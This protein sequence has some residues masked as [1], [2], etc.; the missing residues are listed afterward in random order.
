MSAVSMIGGVPQFV[1]AD[2]S[3]GSFSF[4]TLMRTDGTHQRTIGL[5][6]CGGNL[7]M[8]VAGTSFVYAMCYNAVYGIDPINDVVSWI[9]PVS[10]VNS[11]TFAMVWRPA[12]LTGA[13][14]GDLL[15][16][17]ATG[18][19]ATLLGLFVPDFTGGPVVPTAHINYT[20]FGAVG[21][22]PVI[23]A[24]GAIYLF[25]GGGTPKLTKVSLI[26]GSTLATV[27]L[28]VSPVTMNLAGDGTLVVTSSIAGGLYALSGITITNGSPGT[29]TLKWQVGSSTFSVAP[30]FP[31]F[32]T[33]PAI[34]PDG[35]VVAGGIIDMLTANS[36]G[37]SQELSA[38]AAPGPSFLYG[39]PQWGVAGDP[40]NRGSAPGFD[41]TTT[42][43]CGAN[44]LCVLNHCIGT[45]RTAST[46]AAGQGCILANCGPCPIDSACRAGEVCNAGVCLSCNRATNPSCC[47][48]NAECGTGACVQ[49][50][51]RA[52]PSASASGVWLK[53]L[54]AQTSNTF[55]Q[56]QG[57]DGTLYVLDQV[58]LPSV[59]AFASDG[60]VLWTSPA[61]PTGIVLGPQL[62][63]VRVGA[64]DVLFAISTSSNT[65][66]TAVV[67]AAGFG[68]WK[69][70]VMTGLNASISAMAQGVSSALTPN[71]P[72]VYMSGSGKLWAVDPVAA[73]GGTFNPLWQQPNT[74]CTEPAT[75]G[76]NWV[77]VGSDATVYH[78]CSDGSVQAWHP[79]G[80]VLQ[81]LGLSRP[82][83]LLYTSTPTVLYP[84][85]P[86]P[87]PALA[88][89]PGNPDVLYLSQ[90]T[91]ALVSSVLRV[92][93]AGV[94]SRTE[95]LA[96]ANVGFVVDGAGNALA[97][98]TNTTQ[99]WAAIT[100]AGALAGTQSG[101]YSFSGA[102][103]MM[104]TDG[105]AWFVDQKATPYAVVGLQVNSLA[106]PTQAVRFVAQGGL[107]WDLTTALGF[108]PNAQST[109]GS[110]ML[111]GDNNLGGLGYAN[112]MLSG[113]PLSSGS[114]A[115]TTWGTA[116][117]DSQHRASLK[118]Q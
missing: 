66:F 69:S 3:G 23:D 11:Q 114:A 115:L 108:L 92:S 101:V 45:C 35:G 46:C 24:A 65:F 49:G 54:T 39:T 50:L 59:H 98:S 16:T 68:G 116:G 15:V 95:V 52:M 30:A 106:T 94:A 109:T 4:V 29:A 77:M 62:M 105:L 25:L 34:A 32:S 85:A 20:N 55:P 10:L 44:Q 8:L 82:G 118:V 5:S 40:G 79:D 12:G 41:C 47:A 89:I 73:A 81:P 111:F 97:F 103:V 88:A 31:A 78:L 80:Q 67:S 1:R 56:V 64:Q 14:A 110:A 96:N 27:T 18:G 72:A 17:T 21:L 6:G 71:K 74:G 9:Y 83:A 57:T 33:V 53:P 61:A 2:N 58:G 26:D 104:T 38:L 43:T 102:N 22:N 7:N 117:G 84:S 51:C 86:A 75:A 13:A 87:R 112:R 91:A 99:N 107:G 113:I 28:P 60:T 76:G 37:V 48:T 36:T 19:N 90:G 42:A 93:A 63:V 100:P 70:V